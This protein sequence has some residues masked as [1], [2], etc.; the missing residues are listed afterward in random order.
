MQRSSWI[1]IVVFALVTC[2]TAWVIMASK[3]EAF[4]RVSDDGVLTISGT[5]YS[6]KSLYVTSNAVDE[7]F[8]V[9]TL[10]PESLGRQAIA[11][12]AYSGKDQ[13]FVMDDTFEAWRPIASTFEPQG[14][15]RFAVGPSVKIDLAKFDSWRT[16]TLKMPPEGAVS[17]EQY[18]TY[19]VDDQLP[20]YL[21]T[22]T[23]QQKG[24]GDTFYRTR[25]TETQKDSKDIRMP[26]NG[27]NKKVSLTL[28]TN[29]FINKGS[30]ACAF[31][32]VN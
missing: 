2:L 19:R 18:I 23:V 24:C 26:V 11:T 3:P 9:Y 13:L 5:G 31:T 29:W 1:M 12:V 14:Q 10:Q 16:D 17:Y 28:V 22:T 32:S 30:A 7:S 27:V 15:T 25:N 8:S 21:E 6:A 4:V 20:V